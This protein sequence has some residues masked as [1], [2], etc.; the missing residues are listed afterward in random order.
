MKWLK[1]NIF[2]LG[3][4]VFSSC[5][6]EIEVVEKKF[7]NGNDE[8]VVV[9]QKVGEEKI[10][11]R[12]TEYYENGTTKI[13]G[14]FVENDK[15]NGKWSYWYENGNLWSECD[16]QNGLRHGKSVVYFEN[17]TKRYEGNFENDKP[18]GIWYFWD[19]NGTL[20]NEKNYNQP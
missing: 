11:L 9:Y 18:V 7:E 2:F 5:N 15:R 17:G 16:Y 13:V 8:R 6:S 20:A 4:V 12:E 3:L 19:E 14:S 10:K 1:I